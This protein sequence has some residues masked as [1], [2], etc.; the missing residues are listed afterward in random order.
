MMDK[1]KYFAAAGLTALAASPVF[2]LEAPAP[3]GPA[4]AAA[5]AA[6]TI[7]KGDTA[8]MIIATVLV[9]LMIVPGLALFYGGL[10]PHPGARRRVPRD[11]YLGHLRLLDGVR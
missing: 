1:I 11:D 2:A 6:T 9:M 4:M 3:T 7:A 10:A 5:E 8:F